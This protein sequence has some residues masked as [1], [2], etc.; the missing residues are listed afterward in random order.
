MERIVILHFV[1]ITTA[2]IKNGDLGLLHFYFTLGARGFVF[3]SGSDCDE[4]VTIA[5]SPLNF[6]RKQQEK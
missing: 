1:F 3:L 4:L 6:H 2:L 5:A